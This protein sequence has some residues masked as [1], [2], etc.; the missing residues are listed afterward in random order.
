MPCS[1]NFDCTLKYKTKRRI[2]SRM[3]SN[4]DSFDDCVTK[5]TRS[6]DDDR[7]N[8][9]K[10]RLSRSLSRTVSESDCHCYCSMIHDPCNEEPSQT[11]M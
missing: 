1:P 11:G 5:C 3:N 7:T 6:S 2:G 8:S 4:G 9:G 10:S